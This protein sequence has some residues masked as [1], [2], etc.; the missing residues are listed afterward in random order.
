MKR[1][2]EEISVMKKRIK[3]AKFYDFFEE[4]TKSFYRKRRPFD[5]CSPNQHCG[6]CESERSYHRVEKRTERYQS[7]LE[8]RYETE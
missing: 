4:R 1:F 5:R 7:K 8:L 6:C 2:H 3:Q